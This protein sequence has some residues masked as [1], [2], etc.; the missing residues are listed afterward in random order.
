MKEGEFHAIVGPFG[1]GKSTLLSAILGKSWLFLEKVLI[2]S[3][4]SYSG[5]LEV[6]AGERVVVGSTAYLPE[7]PWIMNTSIRAN[8]LYDLDFDKKLY[9]KVVMAADLRRDIFALPRCDAT[10][11]GEN[12]SC[13][14]SKYIFEFLKFGVMTRNQDTFSWL[15]KY[16]NNE[17]R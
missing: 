1:S 16:E 3:E 13:L 6:L 17:T 8:V 5:D 12:V 9:D 11:V 7:I 10:V 2:C 4:A 14:E 15:N